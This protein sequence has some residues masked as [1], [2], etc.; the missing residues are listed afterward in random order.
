MDSLQGELSSLMEAYEEELRR[1][2]RALEEAMQMWCNGDS[3]FDWKSMPSALQN[4]STALIQAILK[5]QKSPFSRLKRKDIPEETLQQVLPV[6]L[7]NHRK[8][9]LKACQDGLLKWEEVDPT[10]EDWRDSVEL[11]M[12]ALRRGL[13]DNSAQVP[14]LLWHNKLAIALK[15]ELLTWEHVPADLQNSL[16]FCRLV[17]DPAIVM[18]DNAPHSWKHGN[19]NIFESVH[20]AEHLVLRIFELHPVLAQEN[21]VWEK[22]IVGPENK[23]FF[24]L[25]IF[26][27]EFLPADANLIS[28]ACTR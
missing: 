7:A 11:S 21:A 17:L 24:L 19:Y 4:D 12:E 14:T 20:G 2:D 23:P 10:S 26:Q 16:E 18:D 13:V 15:M 9:A 5:S 1:K 22:L 28:R 6:L 3:P 27:Q 8:V 25:T